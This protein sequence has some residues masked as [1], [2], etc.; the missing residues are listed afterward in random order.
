MLCVYCAGFLLAILEKAGVISPLYSDEGWAIT[1]TGT[2]AAGYQ[3][4]IICIEMF[5]A[6]VALR[7]AFPVAPYG[8]GSGLCGTST[9]RTVSL[10]SIS[11][12]LKETM[13]PKDIMADA[14]HNFHPNYQQYT[15]HG[16]NGDPSDDL[17]YYQDVERQPASRAAPPPR[18]ASLPQSRN[19]A[20]SSAAAAVGRG[21]AEWDSQPAASAAR[22]SHYARM[23]GVFT[24]KTTLLSSDEEFPWDNC[25][26]LSCAYV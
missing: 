16:Q 5:F 4:F 24:E 20:S 12:N 11:S 13:N 8:G 22:P 15:Q 26:L 17:E 23:G 7:F 1:S 10:Q 6:A 21:R 25:E 9:G 3:N 19:A 2:V 14:I 18:P